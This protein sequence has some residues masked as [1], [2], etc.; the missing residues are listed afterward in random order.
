MTDN[1]SYPVYRN[2]ISYKS[3]QNIDPSRAI[4]QDKDVENDFHI[5]TDSLE[6]RI[7]MCRHEKYDNIDLSR[8]SQKL[9]T[10]FFDSDFYKKHKTHILHLFMSYSKI[11]TLPDI[12]E[13][14]SL[15]TLDISNNEVTII[16]NLP[17]SITEVIAN[18]N[19]L[20][21]FTNCAPNLL[22]LDL[23]NNQLT[24]LGK[25]DNLY[26]L[27]IR[28]N[29][30]HSLYCVYPRLKELICCKNPISQLPDMPQLVYLE[31][32]DTSVHQIFDYMNLKY[33]IANKSTLSKIDRVP[34]LET[35]EIIDSNITNLN[36]FPSLESILI[37]ANSK[38]HVSHEYRIISFSESTASDVYNI[39]FKISSQDHNI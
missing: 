26:K 24:K 27:Y 21:Y 31:C 15:E 18:N 23:S 29:K 36:Y 4:W 1:S 10:D 38:I 12:S 19:K 34:R 35:L 11:H 13:M 8:L 25:Y 9:V 6:Y 22:R 14:T 16:P 33:I 37:S 30:L 17:P 3:L 32:S 7:K 2:D 28:N 39:I 5:D 20:S